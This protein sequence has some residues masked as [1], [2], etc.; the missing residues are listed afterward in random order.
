MSLPRPILSVEHVQGH[1]DVPNVLHASVAHLD[2]ILH[3]R[4]R[5]GHIVRMAAETVDVIVIAG[6]GRRLQLAISRGQR[7]LLHL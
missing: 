3:G 2:D 6:R 7:A 4:R 1:R 5:Q